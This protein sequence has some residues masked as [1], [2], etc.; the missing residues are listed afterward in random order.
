MQ[1]G[2]HH[3][4]EGPRESRSRPAPARATRPDH[5][6]AARSRRTRA[7]RPSALGTMASILE[8]ENDTPE[9]SSMVQVL[10]TRSVTLTGVNS[11]RPLISPATLTV[12]TSRVPRADDEEVDLVDADA[13]GVGLLLLGVE[14]E[15]RLG[16]TG[17]DEVHGTGV[18]G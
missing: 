4:D 7:I 15:R 16:R 1:A 11:P 3:H 10:A 13:L 5:H 8:A 14:V 17:R 18:N 2:S 9:R 6:E 12:M